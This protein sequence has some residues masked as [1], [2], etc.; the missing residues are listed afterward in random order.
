MAFIIDITDVVFQI[1][2]PSLESRHHEPTNDKHMYKDRKA[3]D[4]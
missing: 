4:L 3:I 1:F 2:I